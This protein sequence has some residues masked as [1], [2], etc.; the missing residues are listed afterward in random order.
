MSAF[1]V[2]RP[3]FAMV[4]SIV[5]T[6]FG[7]VAASTLPISQYPEITPAEIK[8]EATY[9]GAN[10]VAVEQSVATP[11]EQ[12]I[13]GVENMIYMKSVNSGDGKLSLTV[14]FEVGADLDNS[15]VLVQNRVSEGTAS[16]P[17]EVKRLGVTV[18]KSLTF[19]LMLVTLR[20]PNNTFDNNFL[21]NYATINIVDEIARI[22]GVGQV[23]TFGG[24]EYAMRIWVKPDRLAKLGLTVPDITRAI[25]EQNIIAPAGKIGAPPAPPGTEFTYAVQ[26]QGRLESEK[27]FENVIVRSNPDGSQVLLKDVA[28]VELGAQIYNSIGRLN[29]SSAAILAIYQLPGSNGLEVAENIRST[30]NRLSEKFPSDIKHSISLDTTRAI[31]AGIHEIIV[32]LFEA[33]VLVILVVFLFLQ[34]ARA[35]LIPLVAIPV[36]LVG[37]FAFFPLLGFSI[38]TISLLGLVLAIG[39]VVDD[40]IV[41]VESVSLHMSRGLSPKEATLKTMEEVSGAIM[42]TSLSLVA[43]FVPV[44]FMGGITGRLY[45][46]FAITIA[47]SV[48]FSSVNALTL[49][50][51]LAA[52]VMKPESGEKEGWLG[53]IFAKFNSGLERLTTRYVKVAHYTVHNIRRSMILLTTIV[54][55]VVFIGSRLPAGF[56][57]EED[58]GYILANVQLPDA[59]SLERADEVCRKVEKILGAAEGIESY[60]TVVGFSLLSGSM[61][62]NTAFFFIE[63]KDWAERGPELDA[64]KIARTLSGA[65]AQR[66]PEGMAFAFGPPAIPGLGTGS[67]FSM[68]LQDRGGNPPQ[69]LDAQTQKFIQA[70]R[71]RPEIANVFT[72][73][74]AGVPQIFADIDRSKVLKLGVNMSDVNTAL[75]SFLGG[76]YVNDFNR[77]GRLYKVYVQAEPEYRI[78]ENDLGMFFV[79]GKE[80]QMIPLSTLITTERRSGPEF[81]NRFNLF[82]AAE[83]SGA[84]AAGYSSSQALAALEE[85]AKEVLPSDM[86]YTWNAMSYQEKAAE[87]SGSA[88]FVFALV[89]VFLILAAQYESWS[90]PFSVLLGTPFA[91]FGAF[92]GLY[93]SRLFSETYENNVFAQIGLVLL[94]GL[95][96]KNAILIVEFARQKTEEGLSPTAA[97][98]EAARLRFRPILMTAFSFILGVLPLLTATGAGAEARKVMGMTEFAG[99]MVATVLGICLVPVLFVV[100]ERLSG[101]SDGPADAKLTEERS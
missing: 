66:I 27:Q 56:V 4:I 21:T 41:V 28:R 83:V 93:V 92:G 46:Q 95:A 32:T 5:I 61:Q 42:A 62:T 69:Y 22:R 6:I 86:S 17:E 10:S 75:G 9:T 38:N 98:L 91:V 37:T 23:T 40:A 60:T 36:S 78:S 65:F 72:T 55:G 89:F 74:R 47:I 79:R 96:A 70:A 87:G 2:N 31:D 54:I 81:T 84:P 11:L 25:Q 85:V 18:K 1:F 19:P 16:L 100:I 29:G 59:A 101:S 45:Q 12:K 39:T 63:L 82:R 43:V 24:S 68:M 15:N 52:L 7:I 50:P 88:T 64:K 99:M 57:P 94:I 71:A 53:K 35:T 76:A 26:T 51:A 90:L 13:N 49:S 80:G 34:S 67:G 3:I 48:L 97:A 73:Y 58:Q 77:F 44:A 8:V 14:S 33:I 20:S 30:M